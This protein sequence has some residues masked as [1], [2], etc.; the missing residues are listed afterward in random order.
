MMVRCPPQDVTAGRSGGQGV[1]GWGVNKRACGFAGLRRPP[2]VAGKAP[3]GIVQRGNR[4]DLRISAGEENTRE[5]EGCQPRARQ[6]TYDQG[7]PSDCIRRFPGVFD[8]LQTLCGLHELMLQ[9][10]YSVAQTVIDELANLPGIGP[11][12]RFGTL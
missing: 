3:H 1:G 2:P 11:P 8:P 5:E 4:I 10:L 6:D 7:D 9:R 12:F